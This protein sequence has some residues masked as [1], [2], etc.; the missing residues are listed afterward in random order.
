MVGFELPS[1]QRC[2]SQ[3]VNVRTK[4]ILAQDDVTGHLLC[5]YGGGV[6]CH[7][8]RRNIGVQI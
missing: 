8:A 3:Q 5:G 7:A 1:V 6:E 4:E 2:M